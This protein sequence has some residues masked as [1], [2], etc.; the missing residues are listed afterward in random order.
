ME[1]T[2]HFFK[3]A[4]ICPRTCGD[5]SCPATTTH[6]TDSVLR[7]HS[8]ASEDEAVLV[9]LVVGCDVVVVEDS[10]LEDTVVCT[11]AQVGDSQD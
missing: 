4:Y 11:E 1:D 8:H 10:D 7:L 3:D 5:G 2:D 6:K 9:G